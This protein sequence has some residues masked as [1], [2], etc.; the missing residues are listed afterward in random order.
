MQAKDMHLMSDMSDFLARS[1]SSKQELAD[2]M[3]LDLSTVRKQL[4]GQ[5]A[6]IT[7]QTVYRYADALGGSVR[8]LT[9]AQCEALDGVG[10]HAEELDRAVKELSA[11]RDRLQAQ[12]A[13]LTDS[14]NRIQH[15]NDDFATALMEKDKELYAS[16]ATVRKL[17]E[18][19]AF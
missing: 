3:Y 2:K 17:L 19:Y 4:S 1:G 15:Q 10:M 5:D 7:L 18:K 12:L 8:F 16:A 11:E 14:L 13:Q 9:D 6:N